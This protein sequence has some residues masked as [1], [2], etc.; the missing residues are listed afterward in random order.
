MAL[1]H[2]RYLN[3]GCRENNVKNNPIHDVWDFLIHSGPLS[4][5]FWI[6][7]LAALG[8]AVYDLTRLPEQRT[9]RHAWI[10]FARI[11]IGGLWWQQSLWKAPPT[12]GV[13]S[14][15]NG[16][17]LYWMKQMVDGAAFPLQGHLVE[18]VVLPHFAFFAPQVYLVEV[19]IAALMVLGLFGRVSSI[20]GALMAIN[21]WLGLYRVPSEW[22]WE[23]YFLIVIQITFL[24]VH[25]GRSWGAD[26]LIDRLPPGRFDWLKRLT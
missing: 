24:I 22:A 16:G 4:P 10:W 18:H 15:G 9:L 26:A 3:A 17:L 14:S 2:G 6:L 13:D 5:I 25:P 20:L 21:L 23:Y 19:T 12:Y 7:I 11:T 1:S 8:L